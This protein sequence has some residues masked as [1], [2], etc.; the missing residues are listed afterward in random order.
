MYTPVISV[1]PLDGHQLRLKFKNGEEKVFDLTPYLNIGR[2]AELKDIALFNS[3]MVKFDSIEWAN[4]VDLDP[5]FLYE[6][7]TAI[8]KRTASSRRANKKPV[9]QLARR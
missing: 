7:S 3:V 2:F 8:G 5:E 9:R 6:K 4:H 1:K